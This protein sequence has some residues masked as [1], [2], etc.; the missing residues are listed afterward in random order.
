M[1]EKNQIDRMQSVEVIHTVFLCTICGMAQNS[2][3]TFFREELN[4]IAEIYHCGEAYTIHIIVNIGK[5]K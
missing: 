1:P 4:H 5:R 2:P 3:L